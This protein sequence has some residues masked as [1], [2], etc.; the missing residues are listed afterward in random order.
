[1]GVKFRR[2]VPV[3]PYT[4]DFLS[5]EAGLIVEVDG[6]Q[7][8]GEQYEHDRIRDAYLKTRGYAVHRV[9]NRDALL[10]TDDVLQGIGLT[11]EALTRSRQGGFDLSQGRGEAE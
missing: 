6:S 11:I 10:N 5:L 8:A 3:G 1:M 2:Q 9:W 4:A 7:H